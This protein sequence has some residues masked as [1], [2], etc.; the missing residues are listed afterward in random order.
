VVPLGVK[1]LLATQGI[2]NCVEL[3]WWDS[4]LVTSSESEKIQ[5]TFTP[6]HHWTARTLFDRNT[7]LW[8]S[9]AVNSSAGNFFFGGDTAYCDCFKIIGDELGPFDIAAIPIGAY[10]P[11]EFTKNVHCDPAEAVAIHTDIRSKQ[12]IGIHW[13]TYPLTD[14][15]TIEPP[16]ELKRARDAAQISNREFFTLSLGQVFTVGDM[17]SEDFATL[18]PDLYDEYLEQL[19]LEQKRKKTWN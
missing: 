5:I 12:S 11:R 19:D 9:F 17:P 15:D 6:T 3:N 1:A 4:H 13:G 16:L 10:K 8:G 2:T 14:E 18:Y 7:C